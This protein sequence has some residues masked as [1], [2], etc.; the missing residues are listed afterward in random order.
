MSLFTLSSPDSPCEKE[1]RVGV[2]N[3]KSHLAVKFSVSVSNRPSTEEQLGQR[4]DILGGGDW[5]SVSDSV[6]SDT[7]RNAGVGL[8]PGP[9]VLGHGEGQGNCNW[10]ASLLVWSSAEPLDVTVLLCFS[11]HLP[12]RVTPA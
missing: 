2:D 11:S 1:G 6:V 9:A 12:P 5:H 10:T 8:S 3:F 7:R 4:K